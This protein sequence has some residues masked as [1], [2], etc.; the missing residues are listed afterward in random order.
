M[1][2]DITLGQYFP[3]NSAIHRLDPRTKL[4][5]M[6]AYIVIVF[7]VTKTPVFI[8][9]ALFAAICIYLARVPFGYVLRSLKPIRFLLVF[10][11][12]VNLFMVRT[13]KTVIAFWIISIT[14]EAIKQS[15]Y[16]TL[17]LVL[18]LVGTSLMTLTTTPIALTD[19][20]E[21]LL[22][23][24]SKIHFPAHGA[25]HDDDH[26]AALYTNAY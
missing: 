24:L 9:P 5:G 21:R 1:I 14:D 26:C 3:G 10:M 8:I 23:P 4:L 17:R 13:G 20:L 16:I 15:V 12:I 22:M 2:K 6:I 7:L 11:F 18:L 25:C 19:G